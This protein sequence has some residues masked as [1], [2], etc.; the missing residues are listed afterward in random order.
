MA[1]E[2]EKAA[3]WLRETRKGYIRI[4]VL[5]LLSRKPHHGY[6]IMREIR[7]R[8]MGFWKPTAG[9]I[10]PILQDLEKS[11]Y[12]RGEWNLQTKRKRKIYSITDAG[13]LVLERALT[14]ESQITS[15]M[16]SLFREFLKDVLDIEVN[17][18]PPTPPPLSAL[19]EETGAKPGDTVSALRHRR[20]RL[21][22]MMVEFQKELKLI[23]KKLAKLDSQKEHRAKGKAETPEA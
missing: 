23:D 3:Q 7:E 13:R 18:N 22:D 9:G 16:S 5:T 11:G 21:E 19:L 6:E 8:T 20:A 2:E 12:I 15:S 1:F 14:R 4:A 17:M 10:Y